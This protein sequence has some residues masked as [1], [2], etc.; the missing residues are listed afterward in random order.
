MKRLVHNQPKNLSPPQ[1]LSSLPGLSHRLL[2]TLLGGLR[3]LKSLSNCQPEAPHC[4]PPPTARPPG[5]RQHRTRPNA[6]PRAWA[7]VGV[8]C[9]RPQNSSRLP[10]VYRVP[11][12]GIAPTLLQVLTD[13][14]WSQCLL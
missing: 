14:F 8:M 1:A 5:H 12:G 10:R 4:L 2:R 13:F 9:S 3:Q 7:L 11:Q 6:S